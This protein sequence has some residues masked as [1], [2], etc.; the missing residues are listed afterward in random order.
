MISPM[1]EPAAYCARSQ[2]IFIYEQRDVFAGEIFCPHCACRTDPKH[3]AR[4][5]DALRKRFPKAKLYR[6]TK[7]TRA[8]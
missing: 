8:A 3:R 1:Q 7:S 6:D 2:V 4:S 5:I